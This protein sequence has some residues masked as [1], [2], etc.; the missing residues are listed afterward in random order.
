[1]T[2]K[3]GDHSLT[4]NSI[5][6]ITPIAFQRISYRTWIIFAATNFAIIPLVYFFYPETAF[7]SLEE[8]DVIFQ[9][10]NDAPG[11]PW[12]NAVKISKSEP[13]W[14]GQRGE[15]GFNYAN[16]SWHKWLV[17]SVISSGSGSGSGN[18][19]HQVKSGWS[20]GTSPIPNSSDSNP[21]NQNSPPRP[22]SESPIDPR[23]YASPPLTPMMTVTTT[24]RSATDKRPKKLSKKSSS[25]RAMQ[26]SISSDRAIVGTGIPNGTPAAP[27]HHRSR[28]NS[29]GSIHSVRPEWWTEDL[30]PAPLSI[31]SRTSSQTRAYSRPNTSDAQQQNFFTNNS[32]HDHN[33][34]G[35]F[36]LETEETADPVYPDTS[37]YHA[38]SVNHRE[39]AWSVT[40][41]DYPGRL[42]EGIIRTSSA[43]ETYLPDGLPDSNRGRARP[44]SQGSG[45]R[46]FSARGAGRAY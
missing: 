36:A 43:R 44:T 15:K 14:F 40:D 41:N 18:E 37:S 32:N 24:I 3:L 27:T 34:N 28:S 10:A 30:A 1:M 23:L 45:N 6:F 12:L 46:R 22:S 2:P 29:E 13:L 26:D 38:R 9:L 11:N 35:D 16:S 31:R 17:D 20:D 8:V 42:G 33:A 25:I 21:D 19:K 5:V 39:D 4:L 7:R